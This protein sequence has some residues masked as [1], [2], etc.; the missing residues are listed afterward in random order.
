MEPQL[1]F[2]HQ[3]IPFRSL[4]SRIPDV[5]RVEFFVSRIRVRVR[6]G[7]SRFFS[8]PTILC[9]P[10]VVLSLVLSHDRTVINK[11]VLWS[12]ISREITALAAA[13]W[14][15]SAIKIPSGVTSQ[16][17]EVSVLKGW[18]RPAAS[19][20]FTCTKTIRINRDAQFR[21]VVLNTPEIANVSE[22]SRSSLTI[23]RLIYLLIQI[24]H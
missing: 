9:R 17:M 5:L 10:S 4:L 24:R 2:R 1:Y 8:I 13:Y 6:C 14:M 19:Y 12:P 18:T 11:F 23:K 21:C 22:A 3:T 7:P 20:L 15:K 16:Y